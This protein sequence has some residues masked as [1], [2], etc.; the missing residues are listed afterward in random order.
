MI[1]DL[2][3]TNFVVDHEFPSVTGPAPTLLS[4]LVDHLIFLSREGINDVVISVVCFITLI[5]HR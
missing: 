4:L 1:L 5:G 2:L 3:D